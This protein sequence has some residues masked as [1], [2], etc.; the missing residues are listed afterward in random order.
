MDLQRIFEYGNQLLEASLALRISCKLEDSESREKVK[1]LLETWKSL[2]TI[3]QE[4]MTRLRVSA[5]FHRTME[6][7][8][9]QLK[10]LKETIEADSESEN[11]EEKLLRLRLHM[12][13]R[14]QLILE[15]GR[16]VRLGKLLR[17]RLKEPFGVETPLGYVHSFVYHNESSSHCSIHY[18]NRKI[19]DE[20]DAATVIPHNVESNIIAAN[21]I[22][23][24]LNEVSKIAESLD[25]ALRGTQ[26][27][28]ELDS[29]RTNSLERKTDG[30]TSIDSR[31]SIDVSVVFFSERKFPIE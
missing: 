6:E 23:G 12:L 18:L 5:V 7:Q 29:A 22:T 8:C 10:E 2:D 28:L 11:K 4:Q 13:N 21:A 31:G 3:S 15:I 26:T 20:N 9:Q 1:I 24:K 27:I 17:S 30:N 16:M 19:E 25:I 14:E